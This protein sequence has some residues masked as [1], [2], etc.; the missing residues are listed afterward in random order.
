MMPTGS[1][2]LLRK[3]HEQARLFYYLIIILLIWLSPKSAIAVSDMS[4]T[5]GRV[6][7]QGIIAGDIHKRRSWLW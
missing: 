5:L 7:F 2:K 6:E 3:D 4:L 1:R